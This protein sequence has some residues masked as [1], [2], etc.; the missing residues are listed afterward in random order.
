MIQAEAKSKQ[1]IL[2]LNTRQKE[3]SQAFWTV[4]W[5]MSKISGISGKYCRKARENCQGIK[6]LE[7]ISIY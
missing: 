2:P 5:N 3:K 4:L 7:V 6:D 1:L